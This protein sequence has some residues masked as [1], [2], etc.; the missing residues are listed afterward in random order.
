MILIPEQ[1]EATRG[2]PLTW[3]R[4]T[5]DGEPIATFVCR[6]G[7]QGPLNTTHEVSEMGMVYPSVI[8]DAEGCGFHE[9]I[10]LANYGNW[11]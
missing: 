7:A 9:H 2:A 10:Q 1:S 5:L 3:R 8:C 4:G 11:V 6:C